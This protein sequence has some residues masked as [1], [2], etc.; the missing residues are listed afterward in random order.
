M[1]LFI[2]AIIAS[3]PSCI[4]ADL[5]FPLVNSF[6]SLVFTV[7]DVTAA[8]LSIALN[9]EQGRRISSMVT[10]LSLHLRLLGEVLKMDEAI[11]M[12]NSKPIIKH[13]GKAR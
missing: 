1:F 4:N 13:V 2:L 10:L 12:R 11:G 3:L 9:D 7:K 6:D 5:F 8:A